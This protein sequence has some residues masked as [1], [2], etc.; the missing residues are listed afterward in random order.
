MIF[1]CV[2]VCLIQVVEQ[3]LSLTAFSLP[4]AMWAA[5][6]ATLVQLW[7]PAVIGT[8]SV[9]AAVVGAAME[10][11]LVLLTGARRYVSARGTKT[12]SPRTI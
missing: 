3:E 11:P 10:S 5:P 8:A 1:V 2:C 7:L 9:G 4:H 12:F 6:L